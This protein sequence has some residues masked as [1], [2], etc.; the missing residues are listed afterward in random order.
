MAINNL[1]T[2]ISFSINIITKCRG[3]VMSFTKTPTLSSVF[4]TFFALL[5]TE[6]FHIFHSSSFD[7][8]LEGNIT[9]VSRHSSRSFIFITT[10][11][12]KWIDDLVNSILPGVTS[13]NSVES[14]NLIIFVHFTTFFIRNTMHTISSFSKFFIRGNISISPTLSFFATKS[15]CVLQTKVIGLDFN[16]LFKTFLS[17]KIT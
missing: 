8:F 1:F 4:F 16:G 14:S 5:P 2:F 6:V 17:S 10:S 11:I 9:E 3:T 7:T 13:D 15:V 12:S